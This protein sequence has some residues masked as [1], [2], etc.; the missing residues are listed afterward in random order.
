MVFSF[1]GPVTC[2]GL[3]LVR[4]GVDEQWQCSGGSGDRCCGAPTPSDQG[5]REERYVLLQKSVTGRSIESL[6]SYVFSCC[7]LFANC[8]R[9]LK[10]LLLALPRWSKWSQIRQNC[11][12][13][14][15]PAAE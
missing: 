3:D 5:E 6:S 14:N 2:V 10:A 15:V 9:Q 11:E 7:W 12:L 8:Q 1:L 13:L 4:K